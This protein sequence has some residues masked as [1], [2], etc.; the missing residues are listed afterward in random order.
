MI[1]GTGLPFSFDENP[2][3]IHY[4]QI[5]YNQ[6]FKEI[7]RNTIKKAILLSRSTFSFSL[8]FIYYNTCK[9]VITSDMVSSLNDYD[10]F[11]I[12]RHCIDEN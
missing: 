6:S 3:F 1:V 12:T 7:S 9:I 8:L 11:T 5:V 10:Y 4:I 2:N